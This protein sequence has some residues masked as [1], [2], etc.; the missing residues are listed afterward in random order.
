LFNQYEL[1]RK[2]AAYV[3]D[4]RS[5]LNIMIIALESIMK[6]VAIGLNESGQGTCFGHSFSKACQYVIINE[7]VCKNFKFV[8]IKSV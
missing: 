1:R 5:N 8:S 4:E 7:E 3:K 2:I 6:C